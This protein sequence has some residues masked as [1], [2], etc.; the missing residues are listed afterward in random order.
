MEWLA[1]DHP[2]VRKQMWHQSGPK[3]A[4]QPLCILEDNLF[5]LE[6]F[7]DDSLQQQTSM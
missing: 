2:A 7:L 6:A 5:L 3:F 4:L 1:K